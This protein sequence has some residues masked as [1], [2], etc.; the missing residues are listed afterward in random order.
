VVDFADIKQAFK[1]D[2]EQHLD[3]NYLNEIEGP[4][5]PDQR[6][7]SPAGSTASD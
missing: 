3:H 7:S 5:E 4:G 2:Y 6:E 1:P